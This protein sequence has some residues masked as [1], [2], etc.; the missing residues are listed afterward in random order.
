[1]YTEISHYML[2]NLVYT[3]SADNGM[4]DTRIA[5]REYQFPVHKV[6]RGIIPRR[7]CRENV[8]EIRSWLL[9]KTLSKRS[10]NN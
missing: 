10:T 4:R 1:M 9:I 8:S 2:R 5:F 3:R 7:I 6:S